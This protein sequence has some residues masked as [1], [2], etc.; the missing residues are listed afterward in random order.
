MGEKKNIPL[1]KKRQIGVH[2]KQ[3]LEGGLNLL[4]KKY[5]IHPI[6]TRNIGTLETLLEQGFNSSS[7]IIIRLISVLNDR[8][9]LSPNFHLSSIL[10]LVFLF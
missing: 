8:S 10:I 7:K 2:L 1:P 4:L 5:H 6:L 9:C 3:G